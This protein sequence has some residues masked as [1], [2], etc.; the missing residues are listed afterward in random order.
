LA[1]PIWWYGSIRSGAIK[2]IGGREF[3]IKEAIGGERDG[4]IDLAGDVIKKFACLIYGGKLWIGRVTREGLLATA[5]LLFGF[6][7]ASSIP[8][9]FQMRR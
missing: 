8:L 9:L 7:C 5:R 1:Q 6:H 3:A 2:D 4:C